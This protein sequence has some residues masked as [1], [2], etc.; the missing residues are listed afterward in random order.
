M[1]YSIGG[2][3]G[4]LRKETI[5]ICVFI[6]IFFGHPAFSTP[7]DPA[8]DDFDEVLLMVKLAKFG[9]MEIPAAIRGETAYLSVTDMFDFLHIKFEGEERLEGFLLNQNDTYTIDPY[10]HK[11]RY[12]DREID[13]PPSAFIYEDD[14]LY[15]RNDF[16]GE[17]F[18]LHCAFN[19]RSLSVTLTT[20]LDLPVFRQMRQEMVR[21]NLN[22]LQGKV[23]AD[24]IMGRKKSMAKLHMADWAV[25]STN[26]IS[27]INP[28][29][30]A[31]SAMTQTRY[32]VALGGELL[33]GEVFANLN[34][35]DGR[36][37]AHRNQFYQWRFVNNDHDVIRQFTMGRINAA[38]TST[39]LAP[40]VGFQLT[41]SST[42]RRKAF[43]TYRIADHTGPEWTVELYVN[44]TLIDFVQADAAGF[45][46]FEVPLIYG[47]TTIQL[48]HYGPFG[49]ENFSEEVV[50]VPFNFLPKNEMEYMI[51]AGIVDN[52]LG[53]IFTR[54][55]A[56][57]GLTNRVTVGGGIEHLSSI[58]Q[59]PYMPFV[60]SSIK[61][62][63]N[64]LLN[65]DYMPGVRAR[66]LLN[67]RLPRSMTLDASYTKLEEGQQAIIFNYLEERKL[68][69]TMPIRKNNFSL[70]SRMTLTQMVF[71][72]GGFTN[73]QL[74]LSSR[75]FGVPTNLTT[76]GI[77]RTHGY[78][79]HSMVSQSY[80]LP[81]AVSFQ[82][83]VQYN[84][85]AKSISNIN[86]RLEKRVGRKAFL[87]MFYQNNFLFH[88]SSVGLGFR[89]DFSFANVST[90]VRQAN[91]QTLLTTTARGSMMY[92]NHT[93]HLDFNNKVNVGKGAVTVLPFLDLNNNGK[94]DKG[95]PLV[96]G[97]K[98]K[99]R[100]GQVQYDKDGE[101]IRITNLIAYEDYVIELDK[102]SFDNIAWRLKH[103]IL[104]VR[105]DPNQFKKVEVPIQ[106]MGEAAGMVY[107]ETEGKGIGRIKMNYYDAKGKLM[108][109]TL[110]ERDGYFTNMELPAGDYQVMP[111]SVQLEKLGYY[112]E[113]ETTHFTISEGEEGDYLDDLDFMLFQIGGNREIEGNNEIEGNR[114][115]GN[116]RNREIG[117]DRNREIG[118]NKEI[119][120]NNEIDNS[121][122]ELLATPFEGIDKKVGTEVSAVRSRR[123]ASG[124]SLGVTNPEF[125]EAIKM[126]DVDEQNEILMSLVREPEVIRVGQVDEVEDFSV[127][128]RG[129]E[130]GFKIRLFTSTELLNLDSLG[131]PEGL[132]VI[133]DNGVY[134]YLKGSFHSVMTASLMLENLRK[135]GFAEA[136]LVYQVGENKYEQMSNV[137]EAGVTFKVQVLASKARLSKTH[138]YFDGLSEVQ[139]EYQDG[140]HK[141]YLEAKSF[142]EAL[143]LRKGLLQKGYTGTFVAEYHDGQRISFGI[144]QVMKTDK[145]I[146]A[147]DPD[148]HFKVQ[149]LT[150]RKKIELDDPIFQGLDVDYYVHNGVFKYTYGSTFSYDKAKEEKF[151]L[152]RAGFKDAF[153]VSFYKR[154]RL[155]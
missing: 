127:K 24:T 1:K 73:A 44:N 41:N 86:L 29:R 104:Q 153:I 61:V 152:W 33:G 63:N 125:L 126:K 114:E 17:V 4:S 140:L 112:F 74:L 81:Y 145:V 39:I 117:N 56:N 62:S 65:G 40:V 23:D 32:N 43:S 146:D 106:V 69:L 133:N 45:F 2:M 76:F 66:A 37:I 34:A 9:G 38:S 75:V 94:R 91:R 115:I 129:V 52:G 71:P 124:F 147:Q 103:A 20:Q 99:V 83:Q 51:S 5:F 130:S 92:D 95:E 116:D 151:M 8:D 142:E 55:T 111:D 30:P 119:E 80:R 128:E 89:Y 64:I 11:I 131:Y 109:T 138:G 16:F 68:A 100:G 122:A 57:Y 6:V 143:S 107:M 67:Y 26:L 18:G 155:E 85:T 59:Q 97:L 96:S 13:L 90:Q 134:S 154:R 28:E 137:S 70:F 42:L 22:K 98:L 135:Q 78:N 46:T 58:T 35:F 144:D 141:Y 121:Q 136:E 88:N 60:Q 3:A 15:L 93:S 27:P 101:A 12:R 31:S 14:F 149:I 113:A 102:S 148:T 123:D 82:P 105:V 84:Y 139:E 72:N 36:P 19:F 87:N 7:K 48:R 50:N 53:S 108:H 54:W 49:E 110:T 10:E 120:G 47:N 118:G 21:K 150:S 25:M 77:F 132:E 79:M